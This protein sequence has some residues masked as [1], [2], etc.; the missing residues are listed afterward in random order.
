MVIL[1]D[2]QL[3][4]RNRA[5]V[6]IEDRGYQFGDGVYEVIRV[7]GG[8]MFCK[9]QHLSRLE[10]SA[11]EIRLHLPFSLERL[12]TL[13]EELVSQKPAPGRNHLPASEPG[14]RPPE[15]SLP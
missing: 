11:K 10:Q 3:I 12:D 7:Y 13:L 15:P 8:K 6:D 9:T 4:P 5:Y 14:N 2:E 1:F